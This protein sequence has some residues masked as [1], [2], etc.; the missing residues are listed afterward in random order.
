[1]LERAKKIQTIMFNAGFEDAA[2]EFIERAF[3]YS[4]REFD[5]IERWWLS[6]ST[7]YR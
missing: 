3:L 6:N 2:A 4:R 5:Y 7:Q 1:M